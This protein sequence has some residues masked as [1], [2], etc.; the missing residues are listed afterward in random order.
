MNL[1]KSK[2]RASICK[3]KLAELNENNR[4]L[5]DLI[6]DD[7]PWVY[8]RRIGNKQ[9]NATWV[10]EG[11]SPIT[12]VRR[13]QFEHKSMTSMFNKTTGPLFIDCLE[14]DNTID[15]NYYAED[16]LKSS[17]INGVNQQRPQSD[18]TNIKILHDNVHPRIR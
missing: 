10:Y 6:T 8:Y 13:S 16:C 7:E 3:V 9:S 18:T 12:V 17:V 2:K 4:R 5:C 11:E 1:L 14:K 15:S